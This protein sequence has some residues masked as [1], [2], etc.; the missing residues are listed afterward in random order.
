MTIAKCYAKRGDSFNKII[1]L[2][3]PKLKI[4]NKCYHSITRWT[5]QVM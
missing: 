3:K 1:T 2:E 4:E 5:F